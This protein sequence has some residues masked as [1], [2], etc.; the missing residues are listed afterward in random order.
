MV[1]LLPQQ[2]LSG[3]D[4]GARAPTPPTS[5]TNPPLPGNVGP[6][7]RPRQGGAP[8]R[9]GTTPRA[10]PWRSEGRDRGSLE[11]RVW[12]CRVDAEAWRCPPALYATAGQQ[13]PLKRRDTPREKKTPLRYF[14]RGICRPRNQSRSVAWRRAVRKARCVAG[15]TRRSRPWQ[16]STSSSAPVLRKNAAAIMQ[17]VL[18]DHNHSANG[19]NRKR[20]STG[21]TL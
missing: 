2:R 4:A 6:A 17:V 18:R 9:R 1:H 14:R 8:V 5:R 20:L 21:D 12:G 15:C 11:E 7:G 13:Q 10:A 19:P 16:A 3:G